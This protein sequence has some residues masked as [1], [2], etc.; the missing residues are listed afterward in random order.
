MNAEEARMDF[1]KGL[2]S[3]ADFIEKNEALP[4]PYDSPFNIFVDN[5]EDLRRLQRIVGGKLSK[6]ATDTFFYLRRAFGPLRLDIN[7]NREEVC[8]R[9]VIGRR[10]VPEH[11]E[12]IV[13]WRCADSILA[14]EESVEAL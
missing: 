11:E 6:D 5:K 7:I 3:L 14:D 2:R 1:I 13:Q 4:V 12:E 10:T 8:E 9:I